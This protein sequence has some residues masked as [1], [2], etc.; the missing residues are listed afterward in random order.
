MVVSALDRQQAE[1]L[2]QEAAS[3]FEAIARSLA[4]AYDRWADGGAD[5]ATL[6]W[7]A[8]LLDQSGWW[9]GRLTSQLAHTATTCQ[10]YSDSELR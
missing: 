2:L 9:H 1:S 8:G 3:G 10:E 6:D 7:L 4:S 5:E